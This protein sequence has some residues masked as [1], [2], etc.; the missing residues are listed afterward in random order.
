[1]SEFLI[2]PFNY[3]SHHNAVQKL[4]RPW[5]VQHLI[6]RAPPPP[7]WLGVY[8]PP[9]AERVA[10]W[11]REQFDSR[12]LSYQSDPS[13]FDVWS[14]PALTLRRRTGDCEDL[15]LLVVS[16]FLAGG[17]SARV[18]IGSL[19]GGGH[20]WV[21]GADAHGG[22]LLEA[23]SGELHRYQRPADYNLFYHIDPN[24]SLMRAA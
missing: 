18:A 1:M 23:T 2:V 16:I 14:S 11:L 8:Q 17:A 19:P 22:F 12:L 10:Q 3:A 13:G 9:F 24:P 15:T 6:N 5:E 7:A 4:V 21:E 20:A